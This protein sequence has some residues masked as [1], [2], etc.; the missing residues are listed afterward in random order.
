MMNDVKV[1][2]YGSLISVVATD[3]LIYDPTARESLDA[4]NAIIPLD[5]EQA[6]A[7]AH[8]LL[9]AASA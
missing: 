1:T 2:Q 7:L 9:E 4:P 3:A 5:P 6:V 8:R